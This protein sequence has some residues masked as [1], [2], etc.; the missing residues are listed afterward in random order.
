MRSSRSA[1]SVASIRSRSPRSCCRSWKDKGDV[2]E[3]GVPP[4]PPPAPGGATDHWLELP[5][6]ATPSNFRF[7]ASSEDL[8]SASAEVA[9]AN[10]LRHSVSLAPETEDGE[11]AMKSSGNCRYGA[12]SSR[13]PP[14]GVPGRRV[15]GTESSGPDGRSALLRFPSSTSSCA[16]APAASRQPIGNPITQSSRFADRFRF[17]VPRFDEMPVALCSSPESARL[18]PCPPTSK[19]L[20]HQSA[21]PG[22]QSPAKR[23]NHSG[24]S[25]SRDPPSRRYRDSGVKGHRQPPINST[26]A[27]LATTVLRPDCM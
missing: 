7:V 14:W 4:L 16:I 21:D 18:R 20:F 10:R 27:V 8:A 17:M 15:P 19:A 9:F 26:A 24:Q 6:S 25:A 3:P 5:P 12:I 2:E 13:L 11:V 1:F 23:F 22:R